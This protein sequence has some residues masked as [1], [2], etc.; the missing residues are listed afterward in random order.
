[1]LTILP[2]VRDVHPPSPHGL[3]LFLLDLVTEVDQKEE[4][5][6][7]EIIYTEL[8]S[9]Y[10]KIPTVHKGDKNDIENC[11]RNQEEATD[12]S[13]TLIDPNSKKT[14][15]HIRYRREYLTWKRQ[16]GVL[17]SVCLSF[18]LS[19]FLKGGLRYSREQG[20]RWYYD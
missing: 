7:F 19:L 15:K 2:I 16:V 18:Q 12:E 9:F 8:G 10:T 11:N 13:H 4:R 14:I 6:C 17:T 5:S 3:P 1:M 20:K